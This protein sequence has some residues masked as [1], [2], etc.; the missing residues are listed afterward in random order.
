MKSAAARGVCR[1][2]QPG[3]NSMDSKWPSAA[4]VGIGNPLLGDDGVGIRALDQLRLRFRGALDVPLVDGGTCGPDLF[5]QVFGYRK[6]LFLDAVDIGMAPGSL[7][8]IELNGS[9]L[10]FYRK[11]SLHDFSICEVLDD[12][13]LSGEAPDEV[14]VLGIQPAVISVGTSLS[15][16]VNAAM[17]A[18]IKA[19][20][21]QLLEWKVGPYIGAEFL[22]TATRSGPG[23]GAERQG[24]GDLGVVQLSHLRRE[25]D[26][27]SRFGGIR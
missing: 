17:P 4:V 15:P 2:N 19:I 11:T 1:M 14:L 9:D 25:R 3:M 26:K 27:V 16:A 22:A 6:L 7:A 13:R 5:A 21:Q 12:L 10:A 24:E 23:G 20:T 8:R 18:L